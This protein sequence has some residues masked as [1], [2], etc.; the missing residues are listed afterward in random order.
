MSAW[1]LGERWEAHLVVV[2]GR[3]CR[4]PLQRH[5][6]QPFVA[7]AMAPRQGPAER[8]VSSGRRETGGGEGE[9]DG[10]SSGRVRGGGPL[11]PPEAG[12]EVWR[13]GWVEEEGFHDAHVGGEWAV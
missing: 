1:S 2:R 12:G 4:V 3:C 11:G 9:K 13:T 7:L 6:W 5:G 8:T 10:R